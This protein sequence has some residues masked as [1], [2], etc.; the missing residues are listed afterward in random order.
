M[1]RGILVLFVPIMAFAVIGCSTGG[2]PVVWN[3]S[4]E[5]D[6]SKPVNVKLVYDA[7]IP[8]EEMEF[9]QK[10]I[11]GKLGGIFNITGETANSYTLTVKVTKYDEGS[12]CARFMLIGLGQM[13]LDGEVELSNGNPPVIVRQGEFKKNYC[14]GGFVGGTAKMRNEMTAKVGQAIAE[15]LKIKK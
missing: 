6:F 9:M 14:V 13:Y 5:V 7:S 1:K 8:K 2:Q 4:S 3:K 15:A 11:E 10:D 12:A